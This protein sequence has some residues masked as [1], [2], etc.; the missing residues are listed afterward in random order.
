MYMINGPC[1]QTFIENA[2][3][4]QQGCFTWNSDSER[5]TLQK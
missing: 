1:H 2:V 3:S 4:I 5:P